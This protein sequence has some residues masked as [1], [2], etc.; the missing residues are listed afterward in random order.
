MVKMKRI[1]ILGSRELSCKITEWII[2]QRVCDVIGIVPPPFKGWWGDNLSETSLKYGIT[3][4]ESIDDLLL[5]QP[6]IVFS[7]NYWKKIDDQQISSVKG[8]IVNIHHSYKLKY[9]GRY[10]T[11]WAIINARK[12]NCWVHGTTIHFVTGKLDEGPIIA[13]RSCPIEKDDTAEIL[14]KK[15]EKLAFQIFTENFERIINGNIKSFL[16]PD[17]EW[18]FYDVDSNKNLE[19]KYGCQLEEVYDFVRAWS[20]SGRP[21]PYFLYNGKKIH[22]SLIS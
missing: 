6:D 16:D 14:F 20:F 17:P 18:F 15:V 10:S 5:Q 1:G 2:K 12:S 11:S 13:S 21:K 22:L 7:I 9:R 19:I 4:Y 3:I 8:G